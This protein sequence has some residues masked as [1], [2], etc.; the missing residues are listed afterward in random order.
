M[1]NET[2]KPKHY[3]ARSRNKAP[4]FEGQKPPRKLTQAELQVLKWT[5]QWPS[6]REFAGMKPVKPVDPV[7]G[8][9]ARALA[10]RGP[11]IMNA[12]YA[13]GVVRRMVTV[14]RMTMGDQA[15]FMANHPL[16]K[17][18]E[19]SVSHAIAPDT[20]TTDL[21]MR[22]SESEHFATGM[23]RGNPPRKNQPTQRTLEYTA[24]MKGEFEVE[25]THAKT[26]VQTVKIVLGLEIVKWAE[27]SRP[28][29]ALNLGGGSMVDYHLLG[30]GNEPDK[31]VNDDSS[32]PYH[33]ARGT[34]VVL[35][36]VIV[37]STDALTEQNL[38]IGSM[39]KRETEHKPTRKVSDE[40]VTAA[41]QTLLSGG[42]LSDLDALGAL[43]NQGSLF[44]NDDDE[45]DDKAAAAATV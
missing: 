9:K 38:T 19:V 11:M 21:W 6:D 4:D 5:G 32:A 20:Q 27:D 14:N 42:T 3:R 33:V 22:V 36:K 15:W 35:K 31:K 17:R 18:C 26:G 10:T 40:E 23:S 45:D 1:G 39:R 13:A 37:G 8:Y 2:N 34:D 16:W 12:V 44:G 43:L 29:I 41:K 7:K 30:I 28:F 25:Y 24:E